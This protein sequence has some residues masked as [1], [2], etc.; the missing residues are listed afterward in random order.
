MVSQNESRV[1]SCTAFAGTKRIAFGD[2]PTV[3]LKARAVLERDK[4][5]QVLIFDNL[6]SELIE[7][8][9]RGAPADVMKRAAEM[10]ANATRTSEWIEPYPDARRPGRPKLCVVDREV[11]M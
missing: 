3:A 5:A 6:T 2:V 4:Y 7:I 10:T 11:T 8:D 9:F 1:I